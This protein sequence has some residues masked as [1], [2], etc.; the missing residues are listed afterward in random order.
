MG[1]ATLLYQGDAEDSA[2]II[3]ALS[4]NDASTLIIVPEVNNA[5]VSIFLQGE[6]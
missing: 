2:A 3:T 6:P 4:T 1:A 5:Q